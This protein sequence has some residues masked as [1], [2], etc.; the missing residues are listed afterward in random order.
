[1]DTLSNPT[2]NWDETRIGQLE[3]LHRDGLSFTLIGAEIG[4]T[5]NAAIGKA[6][7]LKLPSRKP[8]KIKQREP[9]PNAPPRRR[10]DIIKAIAMSRAKAEEPVIVVDP[11]RD[12]RCTIYDLQDS[13]CRFPMWPMQALHHERFYCGAPG[14]S[15]SLGN[16]YCDHHNGIVCGPPRQ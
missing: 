16:P 13:S 3:A 5:R 7:R 6:R 14:A 15:F 9:N 12:Y 11:D 2:G 10:R 8:I 1:M 4:V